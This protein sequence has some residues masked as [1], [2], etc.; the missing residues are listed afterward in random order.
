MQNFRFLSCILFLLRQLPVP[1]RQR[2]RRNGRTGKL[3]Q[4]VPQQ[5]ATYDQHTATYGPHIYVDY[6]GAAS[7]LAVLDSTAAVSTT[8]SPHYVARRMASDS[9]V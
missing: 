3:I 7:E 9:A 1:Q 2:P 6:T 4:R 8:G 5:V